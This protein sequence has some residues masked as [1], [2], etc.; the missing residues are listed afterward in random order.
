[1][2]KKTQ[3]TK[4]GHEIPVPKRGDVMKVFKNAAKPQKKSD[5]SGPKKQGLKK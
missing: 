2:D 1:M 3:K 5:S 4:T